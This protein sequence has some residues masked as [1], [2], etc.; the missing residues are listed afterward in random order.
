MYGVGPRAVGQESTNSM[1]IRATLLCYSTVDTT[2]V[3]RHGAII[4]YCH[5]SES[6]ALR[7]MNCSE[8]YAC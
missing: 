4:R 5:N 1:H 7:V 8:H 6:K 2:N 3:A